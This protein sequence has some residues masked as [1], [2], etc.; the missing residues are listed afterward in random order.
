MVLC[1]F[2]R[3][4]A[5]ARGSVVLLRAPQPS[6]VSLFDARGALALSLYSRS[7]PRA[8]YIYM[9]LCRVSPLVFTGVTLLYLHQTHGG[10]PATN[11]ARANTPRASPRGVE[12]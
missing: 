6:A 11:N 1:D 10:A 7:F 2:D 3:P 5:R 9:R 4:R 12:L 8:R